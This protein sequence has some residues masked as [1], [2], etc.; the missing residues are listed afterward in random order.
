M[1]KLEEK[2][3]WREKLAA[4]MVLMIGIGYLFLTLISFVSS[5]AETFSVTDSKLQVSKEEILSYT[6][7]FLYIILGLMGGILLL[8]RKTLGWIIAVPLLLIIAFLAGYGMY[9]SVLMGQVDITLYFLGFIFILFLLSLLFLLLPPARK[10]YRVSIKTIW[11]TLL[12]L[13]II[14]VLYFFL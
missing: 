4:F 10:K 13:S 2:L 9:F 1:D 8:R 6:R 7:S 3:S 5:K 12:V 11:P 14:V